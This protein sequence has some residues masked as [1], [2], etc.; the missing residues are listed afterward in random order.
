[1]SDQS[2]RSPLRHVVVL[3]HPDPH[4]FNATVADVYCQTVRECG[5]DA[6]L[7]D[8][9][10]MGFDPVLKDTERPGHEG[11]TLSQDVID[12]LDTIRGADVFTIIYPIWFGMPPAMMKGYID[13]VFGA[14]VTPREIQDRA[15]HSVLSD[16]HMVSITSSG[17]REVWLD[18][19]AQIESLKNVLT[20][21]LFHAFGIKSAEHLQ[22]GGITEGFAKNFVGQNFQDVKDRARKICA[23]FAAERLA[24][25]VH[26]LN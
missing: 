9:Y 2:T 15:G 14:G 23:T 8:L 22:F 13:R 1:M 5:Q 21:Y 25:A 3:A 6:I 19:Q 16:K 18:E 11:F 12:E 17:A 26:I 7:R 24:E 20:R 4:G 10:A